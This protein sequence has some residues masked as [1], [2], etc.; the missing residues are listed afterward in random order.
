MHYSLYHHV[1][2]PGFVFWLVKKMVKDFHIISHHCIGYIW[3]FCSSE[4]K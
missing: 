1:C 4:S 3:V 2:V